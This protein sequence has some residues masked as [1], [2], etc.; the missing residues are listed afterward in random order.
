MDATPVPEHLDRQ[1]N[2]LPNFQPS[3]VPSSVPLPP[4]IPRLPIPSA[5]HPPPPPPSSSNHSLTPHP[6]PFSF[7][8]SFLSSPGMSPFGLMPPP[9]DGS[10]HFPHPLSLSLPSSMS[11]GF[12]H[13]DFMNSMSRR[14]SPTNR[15]GMETSVIRSPHHKESPVGNSRDPSPSDSRKCSSQFLNYPFPFH[16]PPRRDSVPKHGMDMSDSHHSDDNEERRERDGSEE[17]RVG[18]PNDKQSSA[19]R[20]ESE[21][22]RSQ[23]PASRRSSSSKVAPSTPVP[24]TPPPLPRPSSSHSPRRSPATVISWASF[25]SQSPLL[26]SHH[27]TLF[28]PH[29][30]LPPGFP[31]LGLPM[32][33]TPPSF[34]LPPHLNPVLP[35]S[36]PRLSGHS[37]FLHPPPPPPPQISTP[38]GDGPMF[39]NSILPTKTIDPSEN[40]EQYMEVQKSET[41]KLEALV[42]NIEQKITDPN[43]CVVCHR[44]LSCKSALQ[45]HYRIHTGERPFKCKICG[46][47]F[48]TKGNLKT[49]MGVHRAKPALRMMHQCPVCHK[50]F[51]NVL[52]LQQHIRAHTGS[53]PHMSHMPLLPPHMDWAHRHPFGFSR[54]HPYLPPMHPDSLDLS[55]GPPFHPHPHFPRERPHLN[56]NE[57]KP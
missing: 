41:S 19:S 40:L 22:S 34:H 51:T 26:P 21:K 17:R 30:P 23:S 31:G 20:H 9:R 5:P 4:P 13:R 53:M 49:H 45:M 28:S 15:H 16:Q 12:S 25:T 3:P 57:R 18:T 7:G 38:P 14:E 46:R 33:G 8:G 24:V 52:V 35:M 56:D 54:H 44:V 37:P 36:G 47:S 2:L 39:R 32:G 42:K 29:H 1:P 43:Q 55:R 10:M 6:S 48:T 27:P 11:M 50:Q